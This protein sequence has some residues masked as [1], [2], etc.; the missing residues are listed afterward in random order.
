MLDGSVYTA[1]L[2]TFRKGILID[3]VESGS[4]KPRFAH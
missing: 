2:S 1:K 3:V 4:G